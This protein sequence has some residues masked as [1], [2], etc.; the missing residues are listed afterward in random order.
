VPGCVDGWL[1]LHGTLGR[2]PLAEVLAP[3]IELADGGFAVAPI[4]GAAIP[5]IVEVAGADDYRP[6]GRPAVTGQVIRRPGIA[7]SLRAI[8]DG[9]RSAWYEGEFGAGLIRIGRGLYSEADLARSQADWVDPLAADAWGHRIWTVPPNSQGY[10]SLAGA[11][12][13]AGLDL[14]DPGD[15]AWAH[16]LVE[17][18]KQAAF[19][20][21]QVLHEGADGTAL[22]GEERLG[23]RRAAIDPDRASPLRPAAAGGGTIYLC[24]A[25]GD[26]M[27]VSLIQSNA[28]GFGIGVTVPEIG[29]FLHNRGLGFSLVEGHPAELAPGRRP[30][31]T[32]SPA[33][34]TSPD[35]RLR[36]V[37]GTMGG[38]GQPQVVLQLL[39]RLLGAGLAPGPTLTAPRFT[40]TVPDA[41]GFDT[42]DRSDELVVA[43]EDGTDWPEGLT[44]RGHRVA[45]RPW[46]HGLFG[47]AHLIDVLDGPVLAGVAEPRALTGAAVG[48]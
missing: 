32:L 40:L 27:G 28:S 9:G 1:T 18:S 8:V 6:G 16:L 24:T 43:V 11:V 37:L 39:A 48:L 34:I 13:A 47:H 19:D 46:G 22:V 2:A 38:D 44:R 17:S 35:G 41:V 20:R 26:Q 7:R 23:P 4:L 14:G 31:S 15:P 25:D 12:I 29:V 30:P 5:S 33:L 21:L 36:T 42:W 45:V 3:A 10:L